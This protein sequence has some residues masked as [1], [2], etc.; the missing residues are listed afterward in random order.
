MDI[1]VLIVNWNVRDLLADCLDSLYSE[2]HPFSFEVWLVDND[3]TDG[4]VAMLQQRFPQVQLIQ[5]RENPGFARGNL[6]AYARS[7]GRYILMLNPDTLL[8]PGAL[9]LLY[10]FLETHPEVTGAGPDLRNP[11]GTRQ[12]GCYPF[13]TLTRELWRLLHLDRVWAHGVY[14]VEQWDAITPRS[15]DVIQGACLLL[16]RSAL[17]QVGFLDPAYYIYTEEVDLCYRLN[18]AGWKITW[19]PAARVVH[20]GGQSTQQAAEAMF[21]RLYES[22]ILFFRKHYGPLSA[23]LYKLVLSLAAITRIAFSPFLLLV[24]PARRSETKV[25][26]H[27]YRQLLA[28]LNGY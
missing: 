26:T 22:K 17:E 7:S 16:R 2:P 28:S 11:D 9:D 8:T 25:I 10:Q 14:P 27:N 12:M 1:S 18:Q 23:W 5:N 20:F 6:Q 21:L 13:P 4:S 19:L 24:K 15:V 3:S